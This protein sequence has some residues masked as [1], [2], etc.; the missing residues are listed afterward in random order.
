MTKEIHDRADL[1][2]FF[3]RAIDDVAKD[4]GL[5]EQKTEFRPMLVQARGAVQKLDRADGLN[6]A[7]A[8]WALRKQ[9][10]SQLR[11]LAGV[12]ESRNEVTP[13]AML[14]ELADVYYTR[15]GQPVQP[16]ALKF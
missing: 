9:A 6:D 14:K 12:F 2:D 15:N 13:A 5:E 3:R 16:K 8:V 1:K 10:V 4:L 11:N 7:S